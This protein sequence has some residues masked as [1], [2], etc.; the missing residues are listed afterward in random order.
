MLRR[1]GLLPF[2][3]SSTLKRFIQRFL[4]A[5]DLITNRFL[6]ILY[7]QITCFALTATKRHVIKQNIDRKLHNVNVKIRINTKSHSA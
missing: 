1:R 4:F 3:S 2:P 6:T 7:C 5:P